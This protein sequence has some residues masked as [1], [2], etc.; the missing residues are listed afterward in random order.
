LGIATRLGANL[1]ATSVS[2]IAASPTLSVEGG[3]VY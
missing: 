2:V 3:S 1:G